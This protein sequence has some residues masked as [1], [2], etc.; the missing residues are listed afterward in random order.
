MKTGVKGCVFMKYVRRV[1]YL[2]LFP[3]RR[4]SAEEQIWHFYE[5]SSFPIDLNMFGGC[6]DNLY[7]PLLVTQKSEIRDHFRQTVLQSRIFDDLFERG[8]L[9]VGQ[10]L[11]D[12]LPKRFAVDM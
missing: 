1:S 11:F 10:Y 5:S 3:G 12:L 4:S 9:P 6:T 2:Y 8:R 7:L